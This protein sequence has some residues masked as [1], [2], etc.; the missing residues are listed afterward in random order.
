MEN[1]MEMKIEEALEELEENEEQHD[2]FVIE[3]DRAADWAMNK[4]REAKAE[5]ERWKKFYD[6]RYQKVCEEADR[7]ITYM[8]MLLMA[9]FQ[10]VPHRVTDTQ[11]N[12]ALPSG[13]LVIKH[14]EPEYQRTDDDVIQWLAENTSTPNRFVKTKLTLNWAELKKHINVIGDTVADEDG[15]IMP[16]KVVERPDIF[17]V[18]LKKEENANG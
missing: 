17:K 2:R 13:K 11:E 6:E 15:Q 10:K 1:T 18:E 7:T 8:E 4:I 9:Y 12:Y 16:I 3:D 14:Q 5:K